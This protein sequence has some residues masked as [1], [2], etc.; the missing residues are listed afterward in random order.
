MDSFFPAASS[1]RLINLVQ[2][3]L[4]VKLKEYA[5]RHL[6]TLISNQLKSNSFGA[7]AA[8]AS[9]LQQYLQRHIVSILAR[10]IWGSEG[11][12]MGKAS[13]LRTARD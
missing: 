2:F 1:F 10:P 11:G 13:K 8:M 4:V 6:Q 3:P 9:E 7:T 5:P 12:S